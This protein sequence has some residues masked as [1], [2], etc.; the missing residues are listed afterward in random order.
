MCCTIGSSTRG[1]GSETFRWRPSA[2]IGKRRPLSAATL[3]RPRAGGVDDPVGTDRAARRRDGEAV[4]RAGP[5]CASI[6]VT[7]RASGHGAPRCDARRA[8]SGAASSGLA[9]PSVAHQ[10]APAQV[11]GEV[12]SERAELGTDQHAGLEPASCSIFCLSISS[13]SSTGVS[14][15]IRP[16]V[17]CTSIEAAELLLERRP[18]ARPPSTSR[19]T[20]PSSRSRASLASHEV[21]WCSAIWKWK[22]PAFVPEASRLSSPRS[23]ERDLDPLLREVVGERGAGEP[24]ADDQHVRLRGQRLQQPRRSQART[25]GWGQPSDVKNPSSSIASASAPMGTGRTGKRG[26]ANGTDGSGRAVAARDHRG[27]LALA[28]ASLAEPHAGAREA[29]DDA[30]VGRSRRPPRRAV[31]GS[32]SRSGRRRCPSVASS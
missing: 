7:P 17:M 3:V 6:A 26:V 19:R 11:V 21:S 22:L 12:G 13:R 31:A 16:P 24:A 14:A 4:P 23:I 10:T 28:V 15:T 1:R 27:D 29:L 2:R 5:S 30:D 32:R 25:G 9:W 18:H 8:K 20:S